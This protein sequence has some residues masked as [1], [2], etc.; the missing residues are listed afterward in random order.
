MEGA[1]YLTPIVQGASGFFSGAW[2]FVLVVLIT[3]PVLALLW[4]LA[5]YKIKVTVKE[6]VGDNT[7]IET[8][9]KAR[10]KTED[11]V[12]FVQLFKKFNG[13]TIQLKEIPSDAV[14]I[15]VRGKKCV[16]IVLYNDNAAF[17]R[18]KPTQVPSEYSADFFSTDMQLMLAEQ[19]KKAKMYDQLTVLKALN[20][21]AGLIALVIFVICILAFWENVTTPIVNMQNAQAGIAKT[22]ADITTKINMI[23]QN[24]CQNKQTITTQGATG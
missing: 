5:T 18:I 1:E 9:T 7:F 23:Y 24:V 21:H 10:Y 15:D 16:T 17:V 20:N 22:N 14:S 8:T 12:T 3:L 11:G 2:Y 19:M 4:Y 13:Q 6:P